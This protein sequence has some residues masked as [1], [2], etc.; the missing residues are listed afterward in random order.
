M[1]QDVCKILKVSD[2]ELYLS[3][4]FY[5]QIRFI[6]LELPQNFVRYKQ[7]L[8]RYVDLNCKLK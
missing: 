2:M 3:R 4:R 7:G 1:V 5:S 6:C 8:I